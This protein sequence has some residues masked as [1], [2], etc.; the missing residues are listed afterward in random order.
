MML[1]ALLKYAPVQIFAA[2]SV[3]ALIS[4]HTKLLTT[5][6]YGMLSLML[7]TV[8]IVRAVAAQWINSS[9]LRLLPSK[10][11][12]QHS[13][14]AAIACSIILCCTLPAF[15]LVVLGLYL[16]ELLSLNILIATFILFFTKALYLF[17]LEL[18]RVMERLNPYRLA[19]LLQSV[20]AIV[21][22]GG[23]LLIRTDMLIALL[24]LSLSY[25]FAGLLVF[26]P[27]NFG[28]KKLRG[29]DAK[30]IYTYGLPLM[31]SGLVVAISSRLDRYFIADSL[32]LAQTGIYAAISNILLGIGA[33][34]FMV[35]A[36]PGYPELTK[37]INDRAMLYKAHGD[38]LTLLM[39]IAVPSLVGFCV[40]AEPITQLLLSEEY[41]SQGSTI[42]YILCTGVFI[43]N[44]KGH[45]IDHGLQFSLCTKYIPRIS[46][47]SLVI[48][49]IA[50]IILIPIYGLTGAAWAF[51]IA[52]TFS[53]IVSLYLSIKKGYK[54]NVPTQVYKILLASLCMALL[55]SQLRIHNYLSIDTPILYILLDI[56]F[57]VL[58]FLTVMGLLNYK[59]CKLWVTQ[60][61]K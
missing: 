8:E 41:L 45:Y 34:I 22:T 46:L 57:G 48:N 58:I 4:I 59:K 35:V 25:F 56:I 33:L 16:T 38:Y 13:H 27:L 47:A 50:L 12:D 26:T 37:K 15:A 7:L 5:T 53:F 55:L 30:A 23:V 9:M 52:N 10:S 6:E 31:I 21:L 17:Y 61:E 42:I 24:S 49:L 40:L 44:I 32:D 1:K 14:F 28:F 39:F 3:F 20:L 43:L 60:Y 36:L 51:V 2:I 11:S 19:V 54:F 18:A 29:V